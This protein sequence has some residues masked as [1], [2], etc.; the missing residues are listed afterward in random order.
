MK[1]TVIMSLVFIVLTIVS[2][3]ASANAQ[4][5]QSQAQAT[6]ASDGKGGVVVTTPDGK[7]VVVPASALGQLQVQT[8]SGGAVTST[9]PATG[10]VTPLQVGVTP[11][12]VSVNSVS[13]MGTMKVVV[14]VTTMT[15]KEVPNYKKVPGKCKWVRSGNK[16]VS[17]PVTEDK[18][19]TG[20]VQVD[21]TPAVQESV[22]VSKAYIDQQVAALAAQINAQRQTATIAVPISMA[23]Q[24]TQSQSQSQVAITPLPQ[25]ETTKA[26]DDR[27]WCD[28]NTKKC[29]A[30]SAGIGAGVGFLVGKLTGGKKPSTVPPNV[31]TLPPARGPQVTTGFGF[32]NAFANV[33]RTTGNGS[34]FIWH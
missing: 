6:V 7:Q 19:I 32:T 4:Q 13:A 2:L 1:R 29:V 5:T 17:V 27:S 30:L 16:F 26:K 14:P 11:G 24:Q 3:S 10:P 23:P 33:G 22:S 34:G 20:Q 8:Q 28:K 9:V 15:K 25:T 12:N 31:T 18:E 21:L